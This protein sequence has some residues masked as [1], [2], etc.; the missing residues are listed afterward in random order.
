MRFLREVGGEPLL[1]DLG[2]RGNLGR[3]AA[4]EGR[5]RRPLKFGGGEV[6]RDRCEFA[7]LLPQEELR[8]PAWLGGG[9]SGAT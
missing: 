4:A 7:R 2:L 3:P 1:L 6:E 9:V 8:E 5:P